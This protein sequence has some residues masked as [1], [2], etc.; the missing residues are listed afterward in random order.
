LTGYAARCQDVLGSCRGGHGDDTQAR[1]LG[2]SNSS[3]WQYGD[4]MAES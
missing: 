4:A 3:L 1:P 2:T